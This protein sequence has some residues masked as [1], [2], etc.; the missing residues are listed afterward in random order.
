MN[1]KLIRKIIREELEH[2]DAEFGINQLMQ[3]QASNVKITSSIKEKA[4]DELSED[5][6]RQKIEDSLEISWKTKLGTYSLDAQVSVD[7]SYQKGTKGDYYT[8]GTS[9][10]IIFGKPRVMF[11]QVITPDDSEVQIKDVNIVTNLEEFINRELF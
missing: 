6:T 1:D 8:P 5:N 7:A 9:A 10:E 4:Q 2:S 3:G 11:L